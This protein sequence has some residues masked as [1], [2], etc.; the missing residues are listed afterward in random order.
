MGKNVVFVAVEQLLLPPQKATVH[1]AL[2]IRPFSGTKPIVR[3]RYY[4]DVE[5]VRML[6]GSALMKTHSLLQS[7]LQMWTT[8]AHALL[9]QSKAGHHFT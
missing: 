4:K 1:G 6:H 7:D 5:D 3:Y 8:P 9:V 2:F